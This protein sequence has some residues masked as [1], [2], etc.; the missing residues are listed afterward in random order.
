MNMDFDIPDIT[1]NAGKAAI[2]G[3]HR[4]PRRAGKIRLGDSLRSISKE[5]TATREKKDEDK[6]IEFYSLSEGEEKF[7]FYGKEVSIIG[8]CI[9][10]KKTAAIYMELPAGERD[11]FIKAISES[12]GKGE[13]AA[14]MTIFADTV[15]SIFITKPGKGEKVVTI[16]LMDSEE[17]KVLSDNEAIEKEAEEASKGVGHKIFQA[18]FNPVGRMS[19]RSYIPKM[20]GAAIPAVILFGF[21][22]FRPELFVGDLNVYIF[23]FLV[24]GTLCFISLISLAMR[25]L[26]DIGLSHLYYWVFFLLLFA[27][28]QMGGQFLGSQLT[29]TRVVA[30]IF[31]A[32]VVLLAFFPGENKKNKYGPVPKE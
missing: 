6:H 26:S 27:I 3:K 29:A 11:D 21:T 10:N 22:C 23:T 17:A 18:Y 32:A 19:R 14:G 30:I 4:K 8:V 31:M 15:T 20:L 7:S 5:Y 13:D 28:N 12:E 2:G 1:E 25:R 9:R 24:V 16:A